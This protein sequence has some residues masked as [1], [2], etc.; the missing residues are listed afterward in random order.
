MKKLTATVTVVILVAAFAVGAPVGSAARVATIAHA[1][2]RPVMANSNLR[3][4]VL[5]FA[6]DYNLG[7]PSVG[8]RSWNFGLLST[9]VYFALHVNSGDGAIVRGDTG[10][11]VYHSTTMAAFVRAAH[12]AG[13]KVLVSVNL[14]DFSTSPTNLVCQGLG[15]ANAGH[16]IGELQALISYAGIDG[17][18]IDYEGQR[19]TCANGLDSRAEMVSFTQN[20]RASMTANF[21]GSYLVID[22]YA[23]S[24]E[25]NQ[26][27]FDIAGL[28]PYVDS[29]FVMS[30][31]SDF[32]NA[33]EAP[34]NCPSYCMNPVSPLNTYRFN[35]TQ[36]MSQYMTYM[37][38][39]QIILG[40]PYYGRRG[41]VASLTDAHQIPV[42][43]YDFATPTYLF[44]STVRS[45]TG[46]SS[47]AAH[48]D[49]GD[50]V[51]EWDTWYDSDL[52]C[53]REQYF[54]DVVSLGAKYDLINRDDL[55]GV[56]LFTLDYGGGAPEL[57]NALVTHFSLIP[58]LAGNLSVCAGNAS[59][60]VSWTAAPT[61]GGPV[62]SYQV[63]ASPGGAIAS[64]PGNA[65][66]A[67]VNG[68]TPGTSYTFTVQGINSS[69]QGVGATT[70]AVTPV[71]S[72]PLFTTY[73]NWYDKASPGM[74]ADN[75]HLVDPGASASSGCVTVSG[76]AVVPWNAN[77]GQET[78]VSMPAGTIG[79]PLLVTVNSGPAVRASQRVQYNQSFNEVWA[80]S[81]TQAAT[82]SYFNWYDKA[83]PGM[84][85]D[86]IHLL[87]PGGATASVTVSL[88]G[89]T[90]Q[91]VSVLPGAEAYVNFPGKIGGPVTVSS[92]QPVLASQRVQYNQ[93]FN[94]VWATSGTLATTASYFNWYDKASPGMFNDNIHLLNPGGASASV[95]VSL[96]GATPQMVSVLPGAEAYVNFPG[97]IGGPVTVS[98][99][100]PVLAS[101]RVQYNQSFNEVW[102]ASATQATTTSY[103]N[104]YDRASP[105]MFNDNVHLLNPGGTSAS[106]TVTLAG[107]TPQTV[108]VVAGG[109]VY[110]NFPGQIGGPVSVSS[111]QPVLASQRVQYYQSFNEI[112][113]G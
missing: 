79:G 56:G 20:L 97:K 58:G 74:V 44:A 38:P 104:W 100:Q 28:Q 88:P 2:T 9:V 33:T 47:I 82:T 40:Q 96:P 57:W 42:P 35:V 10:W 89:A 109:E 84:L 105:G 27:F 59:A 55:R 91:V 75:I 69:G 15:A 24:A 13:T 107:V 43:G 78:H 108:T 18:N 14:H 85:N 65:T 92:S 50:G 16:T 93:S 81:A 22:T 86:N 7:D 26:E 8:Y 4:E 52:Q 39:S 76:Q 101:Q 37:P 41:C 3:R 48:R 68:L 29:F 34:L 6:N 73:V 45:Q 70:G 54:D 72:P 60:T 94:E 77:A 98:S 46:V 110:V 99:T 71:A 113:S 53:N 32:S 1:S 83:S 64:V 30:Y 23:G 31:D 67:T 87:N 90:P 36:S 19:V 102:S 95:T 21:P 103:F 49:P 80:A 12:A 61:A 5:G 106:V 111:I 25:D 66:I 62:T 51:S 11:N 112:W 63:M 17:V